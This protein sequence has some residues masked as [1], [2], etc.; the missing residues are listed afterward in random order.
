MK[1]EVTALACS[2]PAETGVPRSRWSAA[3]L[4]REAVDRHVVETIS[5]STV[6]RWLTEDALRPWR[7]RFWIFP[8]DPDFAV[9]AGRVLDLYDRRWAGEALG[10]DE[11]VLCADE[12]SQLQA[13]P[14]AAIGTCQ[15]RPDG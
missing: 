4:A 5:A 14:P 13:L 9:K 8:R 7:F 2:L 10:E 11:Y 6:R 1:A 3:E 12:K 15:P